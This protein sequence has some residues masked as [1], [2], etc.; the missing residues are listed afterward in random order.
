MRCLTKCIANSFKLTALADYLKTQNYVVDI[1]RDVLQAR[2]QNSDKD[3]FFFAHGSFATWGLTSHEERALTQAVSKFADQLLE[4]REYRYFIY[5]YGTKTR[6]YSHKR[7]QIE[8][9][10]LISPDS[11]LKLAISY[12]LAQSIKLEFYEETVKRIIVEN[13]PLF[14][15]LAKT[16]KVLLSR[17]EITMRMGEIFLTR[18][19]VNLNSEYLDLP[20]YFWEYPTLENDYLISTH[21]LDLQQRVSALNQQL[22]VLHELFNMLNGQLQ[23]QHTSYLE[24]II[25]AII[26]IETILSIF[27]IAWLIGHH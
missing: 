11:E 20:E 5:R 4:R 23:H 8:I 6:I 1:Y 22:D 2:H 26:G 21:F 10:T 25:I 17:K 12:G 3:L 19:S 7:F 13:T 18:S 15:S 9:I 14:E 27:Q 16:G 24:I